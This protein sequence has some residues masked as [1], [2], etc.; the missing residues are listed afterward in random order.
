MVDNIMISHHYLT[1]HTGL[2]FRML[3]LVFLRPL[4]WVLET[5]SPSFRIPGLLNREEGSL[6]R[7]KWAT[8]TLKTRYRKERHASLTRR[9]RPEDRS[10]NLQRRESGRLAA[11][12]IFGAVYSFI[13][14][15]KTLQDLTPHVFNGAVG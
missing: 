3:T 7:P 6:C 1:G 5:T 8:C 9:Q 13:D 15:R 11:C 2:E 14:T 12:D 4:P 10:N